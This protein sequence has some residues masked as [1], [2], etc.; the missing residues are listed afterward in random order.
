MKIRELLEAASGGGTG[1]GAISTA[2][3]PGGKP[4]SQ[5]GTFFGGTFERIAKVKT[6]K[7]KVV[8]R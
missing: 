1:S 4:A 6:K 7:N 8:R 5:V 2:V 3:N